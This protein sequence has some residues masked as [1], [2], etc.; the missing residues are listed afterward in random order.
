[1]PVHDTEADSGVLLDLPLQVLGELLVALRGHYRERIDVKATPASALLIDAQ[2]QPAPDRLPP[3]P[4]APHVAQAADLEHVGIVPALAQRRVGEDE[5]ERLLQAQ[6]PLLVPHDQVVGTFGVVAVGLVAL[7]GVGPATR[8]VGGEVAIVN[9]LGG[10]GVLKEGAVVGM[11]REPP[12]LLLE[13]AGVVS[14]DRLAGAVVAAVAIHR[15]DEEQAEHLDPLRA[16]ALLLGEVLANGA[17]DHLPRHHAGVHVAPRFAPAQVVLAAGDPKFDQFLPSPDADLPD[18]AAA[19][20]GAAGGLF[21]IITVLHG[22]LLAP[23]PPGGLDVQ[24][25]ARA[26]R[27]AAV[28]GRHQTDVRPV[29][30]VLHGCRGHLD[31]LHELALVGVDRVEPVDHVIS[32]GVGRRV[33]QRAEGVHGRQRRPAPPLQ[34]AVHALRLVDDQDGARGADQIDRLLAAGLLAL[35]VEVVDVLLVDGA[36]GHH[37]DPYLLAD[38]EVPHLAEACGVV[39]EVLVWRARVECAEVVL[40]NPQ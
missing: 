4:L 26:D 12:I 32:V 37:H 24:F 2:A 5:P 31:L 10:S 16:Q 30:G 38:G 20:E 29:M 40:G 35:L 9:L 3:F 17:A 11:T 8:A 14:L 33:T 6:E 39:E 34:P 36:R 21:E 1:M 23:D 18:A 27:P 13:R 28:A 25:D 7:P 19:V 22:R 15:V